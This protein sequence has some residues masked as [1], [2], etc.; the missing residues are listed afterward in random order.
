MFDIMTAPR[1]PPP[2]GLPGPTSGIPPPRGLPP[3]LGGTMTL[4]T[5]A[6]IIV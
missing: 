5:Y 1:G 2:S 4:Q 3:M 6:I